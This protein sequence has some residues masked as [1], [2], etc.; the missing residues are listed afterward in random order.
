MKLRNRG[1]PIM[2]HNVWEGPALGK[3]NKFPPRITIVNIEKREKG[4]EGRFALTF[5]TI[6][7]Q[8]IVKQFY[9]LRQPTWVWISR[10]SY[11]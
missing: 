3:R 7:T 2:T 5:W 6:T 4:C 11:C 9:G 1:V 10:V 8:L